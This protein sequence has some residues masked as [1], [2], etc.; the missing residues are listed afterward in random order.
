MP[1]KGPEAY[2]ENTD[3]PATAEFQG[4]TEKLAKDPNKNTQ[5]GNK[6]DEIDAKKK[7]E[8]TTNKNILLANINNLRQNGDGHMIIK[9][10]MEKSSQDIKLAILTYNLFLLKDNTK[11]NVNSPLINTNEFLQRFEAEK[12]EITNTPPKDWEESEFANT[13]EI[14]KVGEFIDISPSRQE[15][16][17]KGINE[18]IKK[19]LP[20][21][22]TLIGKADATRVSQLGEAKVTQMFKTLRWTLIAKWF[23]KNKL[24]DANFLNV[25]GKTS[26]EK[27]AILNKGFSYSRAMM[28]IAWLS[29]DQVGYLAKMKINPIDTSGTQIVGTEKKWDNYTGWGIIIESPENSDGIVALTKNKETL[30]NVVKV[31]FNIN[32][33]V[34]GS[35]NRYYNVGAI[36]LDISNKDRNNIVQINNIPFNKWNVPGFSWDTKGSNTAFGQLNEAWI[37]IDRKDPRIQQRTIENNGKSSDVWEMPALGNDMNSYLLA[38]QEFKKNSNGDKWKENYVDTIS[39]LLTEYTKVN[40]TLEDQKSKVYVNI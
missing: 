34:L 36:R 2:K 31:G 33:V 7:Q 16:I 25:Q 28:Q 22:L 18:I 11:R 40:A 4:Q 30:L 26:Q 13:E 20:C 6:L 27:Q 3:T 23:P 8:Y 10:L 32:Y 5:V 14:Q 29:A 17:S 21:M 19:K 39:K 24:P 35:D 37:L 38:L 9:E 1:Q 12:N 15:S